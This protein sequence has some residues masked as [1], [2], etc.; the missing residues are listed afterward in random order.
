MHGQWFAL[1]KNKITKPWFYLEGFI[2]HFFLKAM[3]NKNKP[4]V[5]KNC[6]ESKTLLIFAPKLAKA[7]QKRESHMVPSFACIRLLYFAFV[8]VKTRKQYQ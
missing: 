4:V 3:K 5:H 1:Q 2:F 8:V 6:S 7:L